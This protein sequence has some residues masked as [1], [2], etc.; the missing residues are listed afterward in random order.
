MRGLVVVA[1]M[2]GCGFEHGVASSSTG[3]SGADD[4]P[5]NL[6]DAP[7]GVIDA[8]PD[9]PPAACPDD[10]GDGVCNS[11]DDWPCGAKPASAPASVAWTAN[12][13]ATAISITLTSINNTG[14]Y[15]V[16]PAATNIALTMHISIADTACPSGCID[17]IEVGWVPPGTRSACV[18][19]N[20]VSKQSGYTG[21]Y[22]GT[23]KTP[24]AAG[25]HDLRVALGQNYS[26]T[27]NGATNWWDGA[28]PA[29]NHTIAKLCVH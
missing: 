9:S 27:Y 24:S 18:F 10:D 29:D 13:G 16:A 20:T 7:R 1:L 26:C 2:A 25:A 11:V 8:P 6:I 5:P 4:A 19:D 14:L 12:S 15:A 22:T 17:Q 23:I 28:A 3:D 21:T